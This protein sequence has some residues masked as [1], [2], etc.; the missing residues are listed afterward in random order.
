MKVDTSGWTVEDHIVLAVS[1]GVDSMCL[2]YALTHLYRDT[3]RKLTC[4]HVN[5]GLREESIEE[6]RFFQTYCEQHHLSYDI[7]HL[8]LSHLV[9]SGKSIQ[10]D[11]RQMR[12]QWF[13][14]K[15]HEL[16]ADVLLTAHH[17]D[18][19]LETIFYRLFSGR[20]TRS[21]LGMSY[22]TAREQYKIC[23]PLLQTHKQDIR[24]FQQV[25]HVPFY[26]DESNH[27]NKYARNDIRN[28]LLPAIDEN[29]DF[30][31]EQLLKLKHWHDMQLQL[32][33]QRISCFI[34]QHVNIH[35]NKERIQLSRASFNQLDEISKM[36]LLDRLFEMLQL[37]KSFS[38]KNYNEWFEQIE[39]KQSQIKIP[40]TEKWIIQIAYDKF[41]IMAHYEQSLLEEQIVTHPYTY[42]FGHYLITIHPNE[43]D[44]AIDWPLTIRTRRDGDKFKLNGSH[45]HKKVSRLFIDKKIDSI[46]RT[47]IPI[48]LDA[49]Q[50]VIAIGQLYVTTS[51]KHI[52]D[53]KKIG[54]DS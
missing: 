14:Y 12:Y 9:A 45:G 17:L 34:E 49:K 11:S 53:I 1:T 52:I 15:M 4:L 33:Q 43:N 47:Q 18:D 5:H 29:K 19:Q 10:N 23:R 40:L 42:Q 37:N 7:K 32:T 28:R 54:D 6:E 38:E 27:H 35:L 25:H 20:A 2:L 48:I 36:I 21:R 46:E 16:N 39:S 44:K 31:V 3:Y 24:Y 26:E 50:R 30:N 22:L 13:D 51:F 41:I 8:D